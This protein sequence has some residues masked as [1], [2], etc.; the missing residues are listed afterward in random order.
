MLEQQDLP[1]SLFEQGSDDLQR[2]GPGKTIAIIGGMGQMGQLFGRFFEAQGYRVVIADPLAGNNNREVMMMSDMVLFAVPLHETVKIILDLVPYAR[3]GQLLMDLS[4]L[5]VGPIQAML[6][7]PSSVLGLHPMFGGS[8]SSFAGQTMVACP[9]RIDPSEWGF[10]RRLFE[11]KGMRIKE[12]TPE[13]HDRMMSIIQVL[14]HVTTMLTGR[15]LRELEVDVTETMEFTSP[16][17]RLEMNLLG[18]IFAQNA[19]L[20]SAITQMNPYTPE[21]LDH[22]QTGLKCYEEWYAAADFAAFV[23]DFNR[24][25]EHLDDFCRSAFE[26]SSAL[27]DFSVELARSNHNSQRKT[28]GD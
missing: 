27:L 12:C 6:R 4:S 1:S 13:K 22:L 2:W 21:V 7:S 16:S 26:E 25:A 15:V 19:N 23:A 9:V 8:V 14:F 3:P 20:Y 17:Y 11:E 24:S 18:R 5:K 10:L 28:E